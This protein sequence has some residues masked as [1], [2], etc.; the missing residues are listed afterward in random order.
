M[1]TL[2]SSPNI[3]FT[4][5]YF[6]G[7]MLVVA[8][9][10]NIVLAVLLW[11]DSNNYIYDETPRYLRAR[12]LTGL[13]LMVFGLGFLL[14]WLFMPHFNNLLM[15]KALSFTY[16]HIGGVLFSMSHTSLIDRHYLTRQVVVRDVTV[17]VLSLAVYWANAFI[18]NQTLTYIGSALFFLHIGYLTWQFYSRF[19]RIYRQLGRFADY[20]PND[21]DHEV[22][23]L[24]YSCHLIISFGIGG[25]LCTVAFHDRTLPF[26]LLLLA[27]VAVFSYIYKALDSFGAVATEVEGNLKDSEVYVEEAPLTEATDNQQPDREC[28]QEAELPTVAVQPG[29]DTIRNNIERWVSERHYTDSKLSVSDA[30]SQMRISENALTYYLERYTTVRDY[31]HWITILRIEEAKRL[32]LK[33]PNYTQQAIAEMCGYAS[34]STLSRSFRQVEGMSPMEWLRND[35]QP[36]EETLKEKEKATGQKK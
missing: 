13:S 33:Y 26:T 23:W 10:V 1:I 35:S 7:L 28:V 29:S 3:E 15:S 11:F 12:R 31:R 25:M 9:V 30:L 24:H 20:M 18:A 19:M 16:F 32:M 8:A 14:H 36:A 21:S 6:F 5:E 34:N 2:I 27:G 22:L 4:E 17:L